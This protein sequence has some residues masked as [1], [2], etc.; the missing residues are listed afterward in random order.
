MPVKRNGHSLRLFLEILIFQMT[1]FLHLENLLKRVKVPPCHPKKIPT[2]GN[3]LNLEPKFI[4]SSKSSIKS[5]KKK[6]KN[7]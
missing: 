7:L 6:K 4:I 5:Y 3:K 1:V 2:K